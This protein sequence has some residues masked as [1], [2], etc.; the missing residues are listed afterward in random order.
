MYNAIGRGN[1]PVEEPDESLDEA[2][3]TRSQMER[4]YMDAQQCEVSDSDLWVLLK[5]GEGSESEEST[6]GLRFKF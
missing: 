1:P 6:K 3:E 2:M 4:R 5:Y